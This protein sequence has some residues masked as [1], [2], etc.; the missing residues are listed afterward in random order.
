MRTRRLPRIIILSAVIALAPMLAACESLDDF[1]LD[2][3]D[4]F[5]LSKKKPLPGE[6]HD[7]FP[8]G[9]P[10]VTQGIPPEYL[11]SNVDKQQAAEAAAAAAQQKADAEKDEEAAKK[12]AEEEA[13]A[14]NPKPKPK[15]KIVR[16]EP[17]KPPMQ[18]TIPRRPQ[19]KQAAPPAQGAQQG[20]QQGTQQGTQAPWPSS[21][22]PPQQSGQQS[23]APQQAQPQQAQ[24]PQQQQESVW[25]PAPPPGTFSR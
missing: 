1:D 11:K 20:P 13:A 21:S 16:R 6:R 4:I 5:G 10:G 3:L 2:K 17:E 24:Q 9:V 23:A 22:P 8:G 19:N 25:S 14:K 15:K 18:V 7:V 12:R